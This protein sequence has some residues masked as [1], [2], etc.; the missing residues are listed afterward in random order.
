MQT[1]EPSDLLV[2]LLAVR[3]ESCAAWRAAEPYDDVPLPV[4][5]LARAVLR[6][7]HDR[8]VGLT[9]ALALDLAACLCVGEGLGG[10]RQAGVWR[11]L[12]ERSGDGSV[13]RRG[14]WPYLVSAW[15]LPL[16]LEACRAAGRSIVFAN[17][18]GGADACDSQQYAQYGEDL[19]QALWTMAEGDDPE[20]VALARLTSFAARGVAAEALRRRSCGYLSAASID[21]EALA[22]LL[23][24]EPRG[25]RGDAA[26]HFKLRRPLALRKRS[27]LRPR[28]DGVEGV[29]MSRRVDDLPDMLMSEHLHPAPVRL[30]RLLNSGYM[31]RHRPPRRTPPRD[32]LVIGL[33]LLRDPGEG[34][35]AARAAWFDVVNR[36]CLELVRDGVSRVDLGW[37]EAD[38]S[39][40]EKAAACALD[41]LATEFLNL[42]DGVDQKR[43]RELFLAMGWIPT[44]VAAVGA[45]GIAGPSQA[46]RPIIRAPHLTP[47]RKATEQRLRFQWLKRY[48]GRLEEGRAFAGCLSG[49][50]GVRLDEY[51][52]LHLALLL[53]APAGADPKAAD[54]EARS[55]ARAIDG[56]IEP[57]RRRTRASCSVLWVP[58][59]HADPEAWRLGWRLARGEAGRLSQP[60]NLPTPPPPW[61]A[62]AVA[63]MVCAAWLNAVEQ[64]IAHE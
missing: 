9:P 60:Q 44:A 59:D 15:A 53:P 32:M 14:A 58:D 7:M 19:R 43:R 2:T 23:D 34:A 17:E 62:G 18:P 46:G 37:S 42:G 24:L 26:T 21:H 50:N 27:G 13:P 63:T 6:R 16:A 28:S 51:A 11:K 1:P 22:S 57:W 56:L 40:R 55:D 41:S 4:L 30:D 10:W 5:G 20:A 33:S 29:V 45:A 54:G 25:E 12:Y 3:P 49:R 52:Q 61:E 38:S 48:V 8:H 35:G 31:T 64:A 39:G 47:E 36:L